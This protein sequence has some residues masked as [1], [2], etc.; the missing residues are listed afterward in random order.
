MAQ[1]TFD[2]TIVKTPEIAEDWFAKKHRSYFLWE[3]G[4][5]P[6]IVIEVVSNRKGAEADQ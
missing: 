2:P 4:K 5:S 1:T 6:E 3:F